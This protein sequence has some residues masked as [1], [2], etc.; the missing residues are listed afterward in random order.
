LGYALWRRLGLFKHGKMHDPEYAYGIYRRHFDRAGVQTLGRTF[1]QLE[2]GPGDSLLSALVGRALGAERTIQVDVG[3]FASL[4]LQPYRDAAA[5][6][7]RQGL[8]VPPPAKELLD[9][10]HN[11]SVLDLVAAVGGEYHTDGLTSLQQIP[12]CSVD[13]V[14]SNAVLEHVRYHEMEP[15]LAEIRRVLRPDGTCSHRIDLRDHL[16]GRLNNLR[17][18]HAVWESPLMA[19]SGFYTNRIRFGQFVT[20]FEEAGFDVHSL[21]VDRWDALPTPR[22]KIASGFQNLDEDDLLVSGFDVLLRAV[23]S[24]RS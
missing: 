9:A 19:E 22:E 13:F 17:F 21:A 11:A 16:G 14:F 15:L 10:P 20:K 24:E 18:S 2:L 5:L 6:L 23:P 12:S 1:T 8:A 4:E 3:P 7:A